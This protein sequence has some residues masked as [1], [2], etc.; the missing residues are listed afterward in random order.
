MEPLASLALARL[1]ETAA[2][3]TDGVEALL[4]TAAPD[5]MLPLERALKLAIVKFLIIIARRLSFKAS[6]GKIC[7]LRE[8]VRAYVQLFFCV[9]LRVM[10][11]FRSTISRGKKA[12]F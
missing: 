11:K 4:I 1:L 12:S 8:D 10:Y 3:S 7:L 5:A 6:W 2:R 9:R